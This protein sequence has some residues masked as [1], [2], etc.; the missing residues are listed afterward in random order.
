MTTTFA[1]KLCEQKKDF[2]NF[3]NQSKPFVGSVL[4]FWDNEAN[5]FIYGLV[6]KKRCYEKIRPEDFRSCI[7]N[8]FGH[9]QLINISAISVAKIEDG[10][11]NI[12]WKEALDNIRNTFD[13][14]H[15]KVEIVSQNEANLQFVNASI[16]KEEVE[17]GDID[18]YMEQFAN[19]T[20]ELETDFAK[21]AES[22]Q[23]PCTE[24]FV[25]LR[26]K[27]DNDALIDYNLQYQP[28][29]IQ[30][31]VKKF[32]FRYT[33]L[34]DEELVVLIYM[35][36]DAADV[37]SQH[38]FDVGKVRQKFHVTLKANSE[39]KKQRP[40]KI[41]LHL[42]DK[43]E[44]LLGQLQEADIIIE[45]EDDDELGSFFVNPIILMPKADYVN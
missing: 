35:L 27:E 10:L 32:D 28:E 45:M 22:C 36:I 16:R 42:K 6:A 4:S 12:S 23:P 34:Q 44:M 38:K 25:E 13:Y 24:Q 30:E 8:L 41:P 39:L 1:R 19:G 14:G 3:V 7:E 33:D 18:Y 40:S 9:P 29:A 37:Y 31:Y 17:E 11:D 15:I 2:Q 26:T 21:D 5:R 43:L 20:K